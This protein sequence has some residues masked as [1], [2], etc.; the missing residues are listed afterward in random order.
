MRYITGPTK[1]HLYRAHKHISCTKT[2]VD[3]IL[4]TDTPAGAR[5]EARHAGAGDAHARTAGE[6]HPHTGGSRRI[7]SDFSVDHEHRRAF[8]RGR[9]V[10]VCA[11]FS[12]TPPKGVGGRVVGR[13]TFSGRLGRRHRASFSV[14]NAHTSPAIGRNEEAKR[15]QITGRAPMGAAPG[16][17]EKCLMIQ[18]LPTRACTCNYSLDADTDTSDEHLQ[19]KLTATT[20]SYVFF[21]DARLVSGIRGAHPT[22]RFYSL[23][24]LSRVWGGCPHSKAGYAA[25]A[26][27]SGQGTGA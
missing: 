15:A 11:F 17:Y 3:K 27:C 2:G 18:P 23:A 4:P 20:T 24:R 16:G 14:S 6:R 1:R 12:R 22:P 7:A 25:A 9:C 8:F 21:H 13:H 26:M 19:S 10:Y 5:A